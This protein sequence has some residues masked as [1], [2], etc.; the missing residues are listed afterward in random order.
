MTLQGR[1]KAGQCLVRGKKG[2]NETCF[3]VHGCCQLWK[4]GSQKKKNLHVDSWVWI[5]TLWRWLSHGWKDCRILCSLFG[6]FRLS[7]TT[8][9][10]ISINSWTTPSHTNVGLLSELDQSEPR[11]VGY[12]DLAPTAANPWRPP[13]F[14]LKRECVSRLSSCLCWGP[15]RET[16]V[17]QKK[18][19][20][21]SL[22]SALSVFNL[23]STV[24]V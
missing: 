8:L 22:S 13:P 20:P 5:A 1:F 19:T 11:R 6:A 21:K 16:D 12:S 14:L 3:F 17:F 23:I 24:E 15:E 10:S 7:I 2:L 4:T 18:K 9:I